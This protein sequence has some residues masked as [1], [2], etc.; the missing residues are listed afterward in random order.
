[1]VDNQ[2]SG[3]LNNSKSLGQPPSLVSVLRRLDVA[4]RMLSLY[5]NDHPNTTGALTEAITAVTEYIS[6]IGPATCIFSKDAVIINDRFYQS[7]TD[8]KEL[9]NRLR[10]RGVL[11]VTFV[12]EPSLEQMKEFVDFLN[13][14]PHKIKQEGGPVTYLR[15][16][17]VTK[18]TLTE[19]VY[20][21]DEVPSK[22]ITTHQ[23][24][25]D[26][27]VAAAIR[28]LTK[29]EPGDEEEVPQLPIQEILSDPDMAARLIREAV[30]KLHAS[31]RTE[32]TNELANEVVLNM[33]SDLYPLFRTLSYAAFGMI[34]LAANCTGD[35]YPSAECNRTLL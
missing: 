29:E 25:L 5:G 22:S 27:A 15:R 6:Q 32:N 28:W 26:H 31:R 20:T 12:T 33:K 19:A 17:A 3:T 8:S 7:S 21:D 30:T 10:A 18:I 4:R 1:M 24:G 11:A 9:F 34:A 16:R 35:R 13:T 2:G 14:E 23:E